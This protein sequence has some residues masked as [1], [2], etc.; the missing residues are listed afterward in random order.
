M[1]GEFLATVLCSTNLQFYWEH[2]LQQAQLL[3]SNHRVVLPWCTQALA[4]IDLPADNVTSQYLNGSFAVHHFVKTC[5]KNAEAADNGHIFK[6]RSVFQ[7]SVILFIVARA[8][9][10][11]IKIKALFWQ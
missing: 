11:A 8:A 4:F 6:F 5:S 3:S 2:S 1:D 7:R 10:K 9:H